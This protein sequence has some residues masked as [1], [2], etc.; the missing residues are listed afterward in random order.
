MSHSEKQL[1]VFNKKTATLYS[2]R[3]EEVQA[4]T[5]Y[6]EHYDKVRAFLLTR[7]QSG[8]LIE[9]VLQELYLKLMAIDDL[10]LINNPASYLVRMTQ[11]LLIDSLRRQGRED[12]R[13]SPE[14]LEILD[15]ADQNPSPFDEI[16]SIQQLTLCEQALAELPP[17]YKDILLLNRLEGFT[18]SQIAKKYGR[19]ISWVEKTIVRTLAHCRRRL[20]LF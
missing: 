20:E 13:A 5:L 10:S 11:N 2:N 6:S 7:C 9:E 3:P 18:H 8:E 17:E 19:S 14:A 15:I 16:L 12:S 4:E 1:A